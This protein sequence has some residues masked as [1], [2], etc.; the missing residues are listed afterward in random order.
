MLVLGG[1]GGEDG[2]NLGTGANA[3]EIAQTVV[4]E[5]RSYTDQ[6]VAWMNPDRD[7]AGCGARAPHGPSN[8]ASAWWGTARIF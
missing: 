6:E 8:A 4:D 2:N 7:A 5:P 3:A 1:W